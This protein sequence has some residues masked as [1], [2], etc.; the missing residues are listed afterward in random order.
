MGFHKLSDFQNLIFC[1]MM[2]LLSKTKL[3]GV[4]GFFLHRMLRHFNVI[5]VRLFLGVKIIV[6]ANF[7][8]LSMLSDFELPQFVFFFQSDVLTRSMLYSC[9]TA[10]PA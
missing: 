9:W 4:W 6:E 2:R 10:P 1:E 7:E 8:R 5:F 3:I